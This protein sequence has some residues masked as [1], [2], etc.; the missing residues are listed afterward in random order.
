LLIWS[1][2]AESLPFSAA[3]VTDAPTQ[4]ETDAVEETEERGGRLGPKAA[5][6]L[7]GS[8]MTGMGWNGRGSA[9]HGVRQGLCSTVGR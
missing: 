5:E 6:A 1:R 4:D 3:M 7:R 2:L 8:E 9:L